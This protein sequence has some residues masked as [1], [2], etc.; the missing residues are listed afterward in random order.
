MPG[1]QYVA[2]SGL[3]TRLDELDRIAGDIANINTPGY[4]GMRSALHSSER[5]SFDSE[6]TTAIDSVAAGTKVDFSPGMAINTGRNLDAAIDGQ[7]FFVVETNRG[8]RYTRNGHFSKSAEGEL[9][10]ADGGIVQGSSGPITLGKGEIRIDDQGNVWSGA[11]KAGQLQIVT[12]DDPTKLT[13][14]SGSVFKNDVGLVANDV[15]EPLVHGGSLE[16]SN[17]SLPERMAQL[18]DVSRNFEAMQRSITTV[19]N[20]IDGKTIETF[21]RRG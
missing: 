11:T 20:D 9:T 1:T 2:L 14:E 3:R 21:G 13:R 8:T 7:G 10:T 19:M 4:K 17:V 12:F 16:G 15:D 5:P 18:V 6:L